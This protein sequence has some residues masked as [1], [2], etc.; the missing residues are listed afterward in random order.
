MRRS[1]CVVVDRSEGEARELKGVDNGEA[2]GPQRHC[3]QPR[4][5]RAAED[6][7]QHMIPI[8]RLLRSVGYP[9]SCDM[10]RHA[11][12]AARVVNE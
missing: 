11:Y 6:I 4:T 7:P 5:H 9:R 1:D 3:R 2:R 8:S 12:D 10:N